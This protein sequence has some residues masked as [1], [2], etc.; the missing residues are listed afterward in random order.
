MML[1]VMRK[2]AENDCLVSVHAENGIAIDEIVRSV[3]AQGGKKPIW[4][5]LTRPACLEAEAVNRAAVLAEVAQAPLYIVH[6]SSGVGLDEVKRARTRIP[7]VF[8]ET[9]PQYLFLDEEY[10]TRPRFEGAKWVMTPPLRHKSD[11]DALWAGIVE[12][13]IQAT[14]TDHCPFLFNSQKNIG[15]DDFRLIPNGAPGI[16][17]RMALVHEGAVVQGRLD[18]RGF[19]AI[20]ST[21]AAKIFGL[22]PRKG[23]IAPGS[24]ADI[25]IFDP[26]RCETISVR[27]PQT[28]HMHVDYSAYEGFAVQGYPE[29][30]ISRGEI[31]CHRGQFLGRLGHGRFLKRASFSPDISL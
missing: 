30:V 29:T 10:Y 19:V 28:H 7:H 1:R 5:A 31:V 3:V 18:L 4:H 6:L 16:E 26:N 15:R 8:A 17:N 2:A 11:Q 27:N 13:D 20:T 14:A 22:Y 25:V 24:D 21:N 12:G 9:C 23:T